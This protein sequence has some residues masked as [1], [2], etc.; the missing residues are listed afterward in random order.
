VGIQT[1]SYVNQLE[2]VMSKLIK[3]TLAAAVVASLGLGASAANASAMVSGVVQ[4]NN[5]QFLNGNGGL[6]ANG[7]EVQVL[8]YSQT[9]N[10]TVSLNNLNYNSGSIT[11]TP[12]DIALKCFGDCTDAGL[13]NNNFPVYST[14]NGNPNKTFSYIDQLETGAPVAGIGLPTPAFISVGGAVSLIGDNEG[15][16]TANNDLTAQFRFIAQSQAITVSMDVLYYL[17]AY[18]T[19]GAPLGEYAKGTTYVQWELVS[20]TTG[21]Q[22]NWEPNGG[23][24]GEPF[25]LN[26]TAFRQDP[27]GGNDPF[28][29]TGVKAAGNF[30]KTFNLVAGDFYTLTGRMGVNLD[31]KSVPEP[32]VIA[33]LG[34]GL[35]GLGLAR[36]RAV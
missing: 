2:N 1:Q 23:V 6:V 29:P 13:V 8:S 24:A 7:T 32:G 36:R 35:L 20:E 19:P 17:E 27:I 33:L 16:A 3:S 12:S 31:A 5:V 28:A 14:A 4:L 34:L 9:A 25:D 11:T 15:D 26:D 21:A 10:A 18:V 22:Q 30:T